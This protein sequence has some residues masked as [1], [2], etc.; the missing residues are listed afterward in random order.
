MSPLSI[1]IYVLFTYI[2]ILV[3]GHELYTRITLPGEYFLHLPL[4]FAL[5]T[6]Q[7]SYK[8]FQCILIFW[9]VWKIV[10][11][12]LNMEVPKY[13]DWQCYNSDFESQ[14]IFIG[15]TY[16]TTIAW[17]W[18]VNSSAI[19]VAENGV[20]WDWKCDIDI[21]LSRRYCPL[22][23]YNII[24]YTT[25]VLFLS[26]VHIVMF[27]LIVHFFTEIMHADLNFPL[28]PIILDARN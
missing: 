21:P 7:M 11:T 5:H 6:N 2:N 25:V 27:N 10:W 18:K 22:R 12:A 24:D 13:K 1:D 28:V 3:S 20:V 16:R 15:I 17:F 8:R 19:Y 4:K 23:N 26:T 9:A 14:I